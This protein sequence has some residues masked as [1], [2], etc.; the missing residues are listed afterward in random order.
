MFWVTWKP[1]NNHRITESKVNITRGETPFLP[2]NII[3][4]HHAKRYSFGHLRELWTFIMIKLA[5]TKYLGLLNLTNE[6]DL[7]VQTFKCVKSFAF[8]NLIGAPRSWRTDPK[9]YRRS[10]RPSLHIFIPKRTRCCRGSGLAL[11]PLLM[12]SWLL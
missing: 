8:F 10:P 1:A 12:H 2:H 6:A 11:R 5:F 3:H 9:Q 7:V 4:P